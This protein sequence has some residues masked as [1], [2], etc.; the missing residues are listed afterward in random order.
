MKNRFRLLSGLEIFTN[1]NDDSTCDR[2][3][4]NLTLIDL[5]V[6]NDKVF[7]NELFPSTT[8]ICDCSHNVVSEYHHQAHIQVIPN[9]D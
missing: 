3:F 8:R 1:I 5:S 4:F 6:F 7:V 9:W 2:L